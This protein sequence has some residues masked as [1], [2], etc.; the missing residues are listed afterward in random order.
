MSSIYGV[1]PSRLA[2][3]APDIKIPDRGSSDARAL[4]AGVC[5]RLAP[6]IKI[7]DRGSSGITLTKDARVCAGVCARLKK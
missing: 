1:P 5:A 4:R 2:L 3:P 6:D 7:L